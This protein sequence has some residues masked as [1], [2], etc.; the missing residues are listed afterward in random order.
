M[1]AAESA[2]A[3]SFTVFPAPLALTPLPG[4]H[5]YLSRNS[6]L[7]FAPSGTELYQALLAGN[8]L[9]ALENLEC[10][11]D[12]AES[13]AVVSNNPLKFTD[14]NGLGLFG[15]ILGAIGAVVG[16]LCGLP[17]GGRAGG[18]EAGYALGSEIDYL[19]TG[20]I[21]QLSPFTIGVPSGLGGSGG[22]N[23]GTVF[24]SGNTGGWIYS[25]TDPAGQGPPTLP[26]DPNGLGPEW[27]DVTPHPKSPRRFRGP[28]GVEIEFDPA[29]P[30]MGPEK[31]GGTDH[32]HQ[33]NPRTGKR[34]RKGP[35]GHIEPGQPVPPPIPL[36]IINP[37]S[38]HGPWF[39]NETTGLS[40]QLITRGAAALSTGALVYLM[41]SEGSRLFLP[42]NLIPIP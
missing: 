14:P 40:P 6:Y 29:D 42:R 19:R 12:S 18:L 7:G 1:I 4:T 38:I 2:T 35:R 33:V 26:Q 30:T 20:D 25:F 31:W 32:W 17:C 16:T 15:D 36:I 23:T 9:T 37:T 21:N 10:C 28:G 13:F 34:V 39:P 27:H 22:L 5:V 24:G 11:C 8:L 3:Q 41:I